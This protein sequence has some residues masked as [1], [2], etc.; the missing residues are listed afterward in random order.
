MTDAEIIKRLEEEHV[1][2]EKISL[3]F[4]FILNTE[5]QNSKC[6]I[7]GSAKKQHI[8]GVS[9]KGVRVYR[10]SS[11]LQRYQETKEDNQRKAE[12][13]YVLED[14]LSHKTVFFSCRR[15]NLRVEAVSR[16]RSYLRAKLELK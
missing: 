16:M 5:E 10:C 6:P 15:L 11:C 2:K 9:E 7:C 8:I 12:W 14:M 13:R 4:P 1:K 3:V